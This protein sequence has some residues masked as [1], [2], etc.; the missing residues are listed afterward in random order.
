M[1]S[2]DTIWHQWLAR[3]Y[4]L[5][6]SI[7]HGSGQTVVFLHGLASSSD[8]WRPTVRQ[9]ER[10]PVRMIAFDLLGFGL[11]PKPTWMEYTVDDH[12]RAIIASMRKRKL[13]K[14]ILVGHSMGCLVAVRVARLRPDL[15]KHLV[16]YEMPIY[17]GLPDKRRYQ[18]RRDLYY[19]IY[20]RVMDTPE[21]ALMGRQALRAA[22]ARLSGFEISKQTWLPFIRSLQNTIINQKTLQDMK[23]I[24]VP[25]DVIYGSFD[26]LV[27]RGKPRE[28]FG[29]EHTNVK[30]H[31]I[32][33]IH[34]VSPRASRFLARH[35]QKLLRPVV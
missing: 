29:N 7:D 11:S 13:K 25:T 22:I 10:Q 27:I 15:V 19:L 24:K 17:E 21:V 2:F 33:D 32:A 31:T 18:R 12:A 30:T 35:V 28:I 23:N 20:K 4:G 6:C 16:L 3:P 1:I 34:A 5:A 9:L 8:V 26:M 14:V